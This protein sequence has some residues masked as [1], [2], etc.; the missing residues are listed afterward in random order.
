MSDKIVA[1]LLELFRRFHLQAPGTSLGLAITTDEELGGEDGT[2][3]LVEDF[4]LRC[5]I[6]MVKPRARP[7]EDSS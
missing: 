4:G 7:R 6:A 2:R 5:N 1:I 3:A